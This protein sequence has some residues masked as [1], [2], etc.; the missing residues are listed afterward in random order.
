VLTSPVEWSP[1]KSSI[2]RDLF[3]TLGLSTIQLIM[4]GTLIVIDKA[5]VTV[6]PAVSVS[7]TVKLYVPA[8][9]GVPEIVPFDE[10]S[11]RPVGREPD[12]INHV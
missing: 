2:L 1:A 9:V 3:F 12:N 11:D 6:P 5:C 10:L 4:I 8:L 7:L